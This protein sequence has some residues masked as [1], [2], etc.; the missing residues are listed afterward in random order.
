[1]GPKGLS[2]AVSDRLSPLTKRVTELASRG[3]V[4]ELNALLT[5]DPDVAAL[6][7]FVVTLDPRDI[8]CF[9]TPSLR[10]VALTAPYMH[11]GS[12]ASLS[13]AIELELYSRGAQKY[14]LVLTEDEQHDLLAFLNAITSRAYR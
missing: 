3:A 10:N 11:D 13:E 7:R 2:P 8:G 12:V 1:M 5:T 6:G 14:P 9:K 4:A